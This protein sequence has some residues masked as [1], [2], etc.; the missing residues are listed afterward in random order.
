MISIVFSERRKTRHI[1][2]VHGVYVAP[3]YRG[4]GVG[5]RLVEAA[6]SRVREN[7][8]TLKVE[9]SVNSRARPAIAAYRRAGF[10]VAGR[11]A[12]ELKVGDEFY[13]L[14]NMELQVR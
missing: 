1:A 4:L 6:L 7:R 12:M 8:E 2:S 13:D 10:K 3:E 11:S 14:L 5:S 9:L